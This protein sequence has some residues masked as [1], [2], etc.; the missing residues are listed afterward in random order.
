MSSRPSAAA[1]RWA[2]RDVSGVLG[3]CRRSR[4]RPAAS[5]VPNSG[6]Q[7]VVVGKA[8][9]SLLREGERPTEGR[10]S[11]GGTTAGLGSGG[12][13]FPLVYQD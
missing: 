13:P 12:S 5:E 11:A 2:L 7:V 9:V 4:V 1:V 6:G 3:P 8:C 10:G